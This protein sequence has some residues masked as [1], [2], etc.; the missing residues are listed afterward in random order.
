M[1][2]VIGLIIIDTDREKSAFM[3]CDK[4]NSVQDLFCLFTELLYTDRDTG[5][6]CA[7]AQ[8]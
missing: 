2:T 7:D 5:S 4:A 8:V 1:N 3:T 6:N